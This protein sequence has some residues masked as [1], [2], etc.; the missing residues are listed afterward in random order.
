MFLLLWII[1]RFRGSLK[2]GDVFNVYLIFYP[3]VRFGLD[4][5]RLDASQVAGLNINQT[6]MAIVAVA[7]AAVLLW[8]HRRP[9]V[10][11]EEMS[12]AGVSK[13]IS[14]VAVESPRADVPTAAGTRGLDS[15]KSLSRT[16]TAKKRSAKKSTAKSAK[17]SNAR[18]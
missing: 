14:N 6:V 11:T 17:K 9:R 16:L 18:R 8:R 5:L 7:A 12:G 3:L 15:K 4:F 10:T 2:S 1:R 13:R